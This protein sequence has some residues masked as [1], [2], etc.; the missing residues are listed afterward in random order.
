MHAPTDTDHICTKFKLSQQRPGAS[1][2]EESKLVELVKASAFPFIQTLDGEP[3]AN[4]LADFLAVPS[5]ST[6]LP[7]H[8]TDLPNFQVL[9]LTN[10]HPHVS[11]FHYPSSPT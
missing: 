4:R 1:R 3:E 11:L 6:A 5:C 2:L 7:S 9:S 8:R 10:L